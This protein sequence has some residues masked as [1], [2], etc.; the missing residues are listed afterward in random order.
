MKHL[1]YNALTVQTSH[2]TAAHRWNAVDCR[3]WKAHAVGEEVIRLAKYQEWLTAEGLI[4]LEGWKRAG[5]S[6]EEIAEL[7]GI[8]PG[9]LKS[10]S[11]KHPAIGKALEADGEITDFQ[12]ESALLKKALGYET[13]ER[14]IETSPK[15]D[16]KEVET[17]KQVGPDMS[18]ISFWLK[19]RKPDVWGDGAS[20]LSRPENNLPDR[21]DE[22]G[23]LD[24]S[25]IPELQSPSEADTDMVETS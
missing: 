5:R 16:Q 3:V 10:W 7:I 24:L 4:L 20:A 13:V 6:V 15:G 19:K 9:T 17:F 11:A 22:E 2:G 25:A 12:V 21:L 14:K 8:T 23:G 1:F 18:A